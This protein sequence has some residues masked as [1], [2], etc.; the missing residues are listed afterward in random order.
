MVIILIQ[1]KYLLK[2]EILLI[3][4]IIY[5]L[6]YLFKDNYYICC[7]NQN[8]KNLIFSGKKEFNL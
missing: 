4:K 6:K 2:K 7:F 3:F 5:Q 1:K 8:D